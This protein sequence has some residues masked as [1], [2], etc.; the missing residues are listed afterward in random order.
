MLP[1]SCA[2]GQFSNL[3]EKYIFVPLDHTQ[4]SHNSISALSRPP[5]FHWI[6]GVLSLTRQIVYT[7]PIFP[8]KAPSN[9]YKSRFQQGSCFNNSPPRWPCHVVPGSGKNYGSFLVH[10]IC[11]S[12]DR[13]GYSVCPKSFWTGRPGHIECV[14]R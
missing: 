10:C 11:M 1:I 13:P 3:Y 14:P 6:K 7:I 5:F 9:G 4:L 12:A 2:P 8:E